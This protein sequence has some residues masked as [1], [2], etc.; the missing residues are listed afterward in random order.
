MDIAMIVRKMNE[1]DADAVNAICM[2]SFLHS[3]ADTLSEEGKTTFSNIAASNA[4][5]D[6]LKGDNIILVAESDGQ[7]EG[8]IELKEGCHIAMLFINPERQ[9]KGIG[10]KLLSSVL[11]YAKVETV[12]VSASLPSVTAYEK[13]GFER[14]GETAESAGLVYQ[15]MEIKLNESLK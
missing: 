4:F 15:P 1:K 14:K 10:R 7:I 5:L 8:V 3:V 12:T 6:R 9:K 11:N 2:V 13:Y